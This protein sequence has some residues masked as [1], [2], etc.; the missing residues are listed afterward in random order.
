MFSHERKHDDAIWGNVPVMQAQ[1]CSCDVERVT[2]V[3]ALH[4]QQGKCA[5]VLCNGH[6]SSAKGSVLEHDKV[7][8][9]HDKTGQVL[10]VPGA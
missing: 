5:A 10:R 3:T 1:F 8:Q 2:A 6:D 4:L 7:K 9:T